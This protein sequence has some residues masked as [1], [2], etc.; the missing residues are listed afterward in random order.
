M[1]KAS[2]ESRCPMCTEC[3]KIQITYNCV[4]H[5]I[6]YKLLS[7][8]SRTLSSVEREGVRE[9]YGNDDVDDADGDVRAATGRTQNLEGQHWGRDGLSWRWGELLQSEG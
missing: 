3:D 8:R 4:P 5:S 9:N 1:S 2:N 7:C 6:A